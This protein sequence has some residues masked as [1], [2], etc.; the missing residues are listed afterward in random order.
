MSGALGLL[1]FFI[2]FFVTLKRQKRFDAKHLSAYITAY[3]AGSSIVPA[4][5]LCFYV[6]FP[7]SPDV[8]TKLHGFE[9]Y[10]TL[11]GLTFL[12]VTLAALWSLFKKAYGV[13]E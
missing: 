12:L 8:K 6:F 2:I 10:V 11:G 7:D 13:E 1:C 3:L 5:F 9:I 4:L